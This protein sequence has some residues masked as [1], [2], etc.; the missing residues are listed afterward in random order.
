MSGRALDGFLCCLVGADQ[1]ALRGV[2]VALVTRADEMRASAADDG[3]VGVLP[4]PGEEI[5]VY[6]LAALLGGRR[7]ARTADRHVVVTGA[8]GSRY[9][10]LVDRLVRSGGD[11]ASVVPLPSV[12]GGA[13]VRWFEG[14]LSLQE[15]SC[16]VLAPEGLRPGGHAPAGGAAAP[17]AARLRP[18]PEVSG[19]VLT[20][21]S[22][23]LPSAAVKRHAVSAARVA[24]VVQSM[25]LVP[26]PGCGPHVA[27]LGAWR[28][29]AVVV[30]D[31]SRGA[32]V[33]AGSRRFL[34]LRCGQGAQIAI[35][36]DADTALLRATADN[37]VAAANVPAGYVRGVFTIG[38]ED[39]A[40][41]DVDRLAAAA[42]DVARDAVPALV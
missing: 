41:V 13:A 24:A 29:A 34:V 9:G 35:A 11:G 38:G 21:S 2:D 37:V 18:A 36:V 19:L 17:S 31:F 40:L 25:P 22:A 23:A 30:L 28:S 26:V 39:V 33:T 7:D 14:L 15:T 8:A 16:L 6:S 3:R 5:P 42:I 20:F 12:V 32:A 10:L 4:R 27:A 1:Y